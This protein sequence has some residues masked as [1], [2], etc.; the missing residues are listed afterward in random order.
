MQMADSGAGDRGGGEGGWRRFLMELL[1]A[2]VV[3]PR[4]SCDACYVMSMALE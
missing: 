1:G 4:F 3:Y 2:L